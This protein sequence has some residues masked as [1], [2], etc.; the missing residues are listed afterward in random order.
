M[1]QIEVKRHLIE[2][3]FHPD[4]GWDV[5]VDL[6]VMELGRGG[7]N[8]EEKR[9]TAEFHHKWM[10]DNGVAVHI[11]RTGTRTDIVAKHPQQGTYVIECEGDT[12]RQKEQAMYSALGQMLLQMDDSIRYY[13]LVFPGSKAWTDQID[14]I[15]RNVRDILRFKVFMVSDSSVRER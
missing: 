12:R 9:K 11:H 5:T 6:D 13:A 2:K 1:H 15:P 4:Q 14:K 10:Q 3:R 7:Q 8:T